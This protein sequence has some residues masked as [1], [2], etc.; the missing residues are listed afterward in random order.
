MNEKEKELLERLLVIFRVEAAE[1]LQ[2]ISS[3]LIALEKSSQSEEQMDLIEVMFREVHSFKGSARSVNILEIERICQSLESVFFALKTKELPLQSSLF[4]SLHETLSYLEKQVQFLNA[5]P[6]LSSK[7]EE[8]PKTEIPAVSPESSLKNEVKRSDISS[9]TVRISLERLVS[10]LLKVEEMRSIN[11]SAHQR[12]LELSDLQESISDWKK[13]FEKKQGINNNGNNENRLRKLNDKSSSILSSAKNDARN[14]QSMV[15]SLSYDIKSTLMVPF[16]SILETFPK[17]IRDFSRSLGK[18]VELSIRGAEI[19]IDRRILEEIK[20]PLT[21][22]IRN[23]VDH[24]LESPQERGKKNKP[25]QGTVS[26]DVSTSD[27]GNI[28]IV[29]SDDGAGIDVERLKSTVLERGLISKD[30]AEKMS[31]K[32]MTSF[33]F[34]S[35]VSTTKKVNEFS[36]RGIGLAIVQEKVNKLRGLITVDTQFGFGTAF[37]ITL[38]MTLANLRGILIE[39]KGQNFALPTTHV[40]KILRIKK[41]KIKTIEN[42]NTIQLEKEAIALVSLAHVLG[43]SD[44]NTLESKSEYVIV[45]ILVMGNHRVGFQIGSVVGEQDILVKNL[46]VQLLRIP[47]ISGVTILGTGK[48]VP[49][50]NIPDLLKA[51]VDSITHSSNPIS[52]RTRDESKRKSLLV[53]EDSATT[54]ALIQNI[55]E[56][57]GYL[58]R[59]AVDGIDAITLL[60]VEKFDLIVS[61]IDMP[62]MNGIDLI[63]K[64]RSENKFSKLPVILVSTEESRERRELGIDV[65][66]NAYIVKSHFDQGNLLE[67]I[68]RL[69]GD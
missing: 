9:K 58:V 2:V 41:E 24:G 66:A 34:Q 28:E 59:T 10:V 60:K 38:P 30:Q 19:E 21:H 37:R 5:Q 18:E 43:L 40:E 36:G 54:R 14:F 16:A 44:D 46:G 42:T 62:R 33:I 7:P 26:I 50:L 67:A 6:G 68:R 22:L 52:K 13:N 69:I 20:D 15:D 11:L 61:D 4:D 31:Q 53:V 56:S 47:H 23:S 39:L 48:L 25:S 65:G 51:A 32:S 1:H 49:I 27:S 63:M 55:L 64:I 8:I 3:S 17:M 29:V 45:A 57:N 12:I 35:G